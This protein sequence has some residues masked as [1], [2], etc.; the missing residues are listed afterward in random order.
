[1]GSKIA[2]PPLSSIFPKPFLKWAGGKGQLLEQMSRFFPKE[3]QSGKIKRY[4]EPFIGG[5]AV[6]LYIAHKYQIP[7]LF[8]ADI[9]Q[10]LVI[11]YKTIQNNV[12]DLIAIL[13]EMENKFLSLDELGRNNYFYQIREEFNHHKKSCNLNDYTFDWLQRTSQTIFL[14]KTC[15][16]GLFRVNSKG[17][18]NVPIGRYKKPLICDV[19]NLRLVAQILQK[20]QIYY[21]DFS[22]CKKF[23]DHQTFIYFDPP[24]KPISQTS[25]FTAYAQKSFNDEEQLRLRD[26]FK[27]LDKKGALLLLSNSDPTNEDATDDFFEKAYAGYR[28]EKVKAKRNINSNALKR[29]LINELIIMNY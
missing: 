6:F 8:I 13:S 26:L 29:N 4:I 15:Y 1:M 7:E 21:G 10:E 11:A 19:I 14:N 20:T 3:L 18:F 2:T 5:G 28:I 24:Y 16:N 9:N 22:D 23:V 25:S 12:D 27:E 17:D